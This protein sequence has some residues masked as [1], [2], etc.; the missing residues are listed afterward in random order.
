MAL[1]TWRKVR[2]LERA[3]VVCL[4]NKGLVAVLI[5]SFWWILRTALSWMRFAHWQRAREVIIP[6]LLFLSFCCFVCRLCCF[7]FLRSSRAPP[8][9]L[10]TVPANASLM[11]R[12][13]AVISLSRVMDKW[14]RGRGC[15]ALACLMCWLIDPCIRVKRC[16]LC[17][18][19]SVC[20]PQ[21]HLLSPLHSLAAPMYPWADNPTTPP[22]PP[23]FLMRLKPFFFRASF[24]FRSFPSIFVKNF[25]LNEDELRPNNTAT[26]H[27]PFAQQII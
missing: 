9:F 13:P 17:L 23:L 8:W 3:A 10:T 6:L 7:L 22:S 26:T 1:Y 20:D 12:P 16:L 19:S 25:Y 4:S 21:R 27:T 5:K 24:S 15:Y 2:G 14:H 11:D 18:A